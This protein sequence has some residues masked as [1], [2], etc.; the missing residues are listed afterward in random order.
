MLC[1]NGI[2]CETFSHVYLAVN[3]C[4]FRD[5]LLYYN[6]AENVGITFL[7]KYICDQVYHMYPWNV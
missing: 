4:L 6:L 2:M 7:L 3:Q 5:V 1:F